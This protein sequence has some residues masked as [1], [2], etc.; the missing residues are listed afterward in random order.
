M[1]DQAGDAA[2]NKVV[3]ESGNACDS[4]DDDDN[5]AGDDN[6]CNGVGDGAGSGEGSNVGNDAGNMVGD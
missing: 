6:I 5:G 1:G 3:G 2:G 4:A